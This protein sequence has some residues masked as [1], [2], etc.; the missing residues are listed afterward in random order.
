MGSKPELLLA[1]AHVDDRDSL[2]LCNGY[3]DRRYI[4]IAL[5]AQQ[6]GRT[7]ILVVEKLSELDV[8]FQVAD[9]VGIQPLLGVRAKLS[10]PGKGR[11]KSS[12]GDRA[13]FGLSALAIVELVERLRRSERL[14][15]LRLLHFHIGSQVTAIRTFKRALREATRLY[16]ELVGLGAPMG[17]FDVGGGLGVDYDG[18]Q[19]SFESSRNYTVA[20]YAADVVSH[21]QGACDVAGVA[22]PDLVTE[23]GRA[24]TAHC[25][26]LLFD[27][28]GVE[29]VPVD[30]PPASPAPDEH[31]LVGELRQVHERL[32]VRN[33]QESWH[34]AV[35][36][37]TRS[38]GAFELG[39]VGL[40]DLAAVDSLFWKVCGRIVHLTDG[41]TY[42]PDELEG[43]ADRLADTYYAN[44]SV[45][46]S[47]PD[48][49]AVDQLFP[50]LPVSRLEEEPTRRAVIADLTCDSDGKLARFVDRRDVKKAL[51]LHP[52]VPGQRYV[53]ALA[54]VGAY[55]EILGDLHNLFGDTHAVHVSVDDAGQTRIDRVIEGDTVEMVAGYVQYERKDL[56]HRVRRATEDAIAQERITPSTARRLLSLYRESLDGYTYLGA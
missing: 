13:K 30:G 7:V 31:E 45:F 40:P 11:W 19:T 17:F 42:V 27:I 37:R 15:L 36:V 44:F 12:A 14:H 55:Q 47:A 20:E 26:V 33:L 39:V 5:A 2:I 8:V 56:V 1:L 6:L 51:E 25:S 29:S 41:M 48:A 23:S 10:N 21:I 50:C 24:T 52:L 16:V 43:L 9:R 35:D 28:L 22:H 32:T 46:Q 54:L 38:R 18:S 34:D 53:L 4:E 49:W 3:K